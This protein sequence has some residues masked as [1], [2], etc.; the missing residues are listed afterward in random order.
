MIIGADFTHMATTNTESN[1]F[2]EFSLALY[3]QEG[4]AAAC[5]L[6]QESEDVDVNVMLYLCWWS[7]QGRALMAADLVAVEAAITD[8]RRDVVL[9]IRLLRR[10]LRG[11]P[12]IGSTRA[13][14]QQAELEAER[15]Q[16]GHMYAH[17]R[18]AETV[19]G[20]EALHGNLIQFALFHGCDE[21]VLGDFETVVR[22]GFSCLPAD[23][24]SL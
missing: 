15:V 7:W 13:L 19:P 6:L 22:A 9:P 3:A 20:A 11:Y 16:Q 18:S 24:R 17:S 23:L 5:L 14:V 4:V 10:G 2:W 12:D 21:A 8:W 1:P